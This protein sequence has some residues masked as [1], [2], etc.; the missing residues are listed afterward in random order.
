MVIHR[1]HN[2]EPIFRSMHHLAP[3]KSSRLSFVSAADTT[4]LR[5]VSPPPCTARIFQIKICHKGSDKSRHH[6]AREGDG[7]FPKRLPKNFCGLLCRLVNSHLWILKFHL[8]RLF[9]RHS[10]KDVLEINRLGCPLFSADSNMRY[11]RL[12]YYGF[13]WILTLVWFNGIHIPLFPPYHTKSPL[14]Q[15]FC[16]FYPTLFVDMILVGG[17]NPSA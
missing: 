14:S 10:L 17:F 11:Q 12:F 5:P 3:I 2:Y 16:W 7:A 13:C 6:R 4:A 8:S 1:W 15:H 9:L